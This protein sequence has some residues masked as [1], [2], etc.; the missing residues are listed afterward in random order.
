VP[1]LTI[2]DENDVDFASLATAEAVRLFED[3][4]KRVSAFELTADNATTVAELCRH[5]DGLPLAIELAA[6]R[7][8]ALPVTYITAELHDRFALLVSTSRALPGRQ[9]TLRATVDW[10]YRLLHDDERMLFGLLSVFEGG[11]TVD[12]ALA[13]AQVGSIEP[14]RALELLVGLVDK[15]LVVW[16]RRG[17]T[18]GG[19]YDMLETL[20]DYGREQLG[21][22]GLLDDARRAHR[23]YFV[24]LAEDA[25][26]GVRSKEYRS[27]QARLEAELGNLHAAR[28]SAMSSE[29]ADDALRI[30]SALWRFWASSDR[31]AVGRDWIDAALRSSG[32]QARPVLRGRALTVLCYLA[33]QQLDL[34]DAVTAGEQAVALTKESGDAWSVAWAKQSLALSFEVAGDHAQAALAR[35]AIGLNEGGPC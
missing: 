33:G 4:A 35:E 34:D 20:R 8:K 28:D 16:D 22:V 2:P 6:A 12:A 1:P 13:I 32:S 17:A 11:C 26:A 23:T 19:G 30:A 21:A 18:S 9:R 27:W 25:E 10:S 5:L 15:S 31:H 7:T 14:G 29:A 3:R 24:T